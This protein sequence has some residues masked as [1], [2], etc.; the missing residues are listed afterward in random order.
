MKISETEV[1]EYLEFLHDAQIM[2]AGLEQAKAFKEPSKL[3]SI[4]MPPP[5][6]RAFK[7]KCE[8]EGLKYQTQIKELMRK[9]LLE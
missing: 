1:Q 5:L 2:Q 9:W 7:Q 6:L 4:K 8:I 3:I